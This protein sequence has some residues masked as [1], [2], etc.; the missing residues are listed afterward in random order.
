MAAN[1]SRRS[2]HFK[3]PATFS[4]PRSGHPPVKARLRGQR[5]I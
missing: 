1:A 5:F 3:N 4:L 2:S